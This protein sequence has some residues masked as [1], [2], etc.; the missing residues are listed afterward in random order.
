MND[1]GYYLALWSCL[2]APWRPVQKSA[3][4]RTPG[5]EASDGTWQLA[6]PVAGR[7]LQKGWEQRL[8]KSYKDIKHLNIM[9]SA[10]FPRT[11]GGCEPKK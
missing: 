3:P 9:T 4:G 6:L 5:P 8:G 7:C 10:L 11:L 1:A 2:S